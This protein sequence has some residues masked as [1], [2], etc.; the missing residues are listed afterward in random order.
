MRPD[1]GCLS[2]SLLDSGEMSQNLYTH[3]LYDAK[4]LVTLC[5][6][7]QCYSHKTKP[8]TRTKNLRTSSLRMALI[9][10]FH[11]FPVNIHKNTKRKF[12]YTHVHTILL[13][14]TYLDSQLEKVEINPKST[15]KWVRAGYPTRTCE[16]NTKNMTCTCPRQIQL[17]HT[18]Q[19][20]YSTGSCWSSHRACWARVGHC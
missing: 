12:D 2:L 11:T 18:Q 10:I 13:I 9:Y 4:Q 16:I 1:H 20:P 8:E 3:L 17:S 14:C 5:K 15:K 19:E 6:S 7:F